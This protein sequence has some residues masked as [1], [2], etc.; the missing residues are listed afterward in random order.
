MKTVY[1]SFLLKLCI[2]VEC[3]NGKAE[4]NRHVQLN[5]LK[6][7]CKKFFYL[8]SIKLCSPVHNTG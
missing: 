2:W 5:I 7:M 3:I 1:V 4:A 8:L 6:S